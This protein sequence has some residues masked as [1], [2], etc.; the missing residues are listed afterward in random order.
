[1]SLTLTVVLTVI[2]VLALVGGLG[3]L[4]DRDAERHE[5]EEQPEEMRK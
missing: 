4:I 5:G 3:Y 1:M 2:V